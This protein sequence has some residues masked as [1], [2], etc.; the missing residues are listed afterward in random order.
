MEYD[1]SNPNNKKKPPNFKPWKS[2]THQKPDVNPKPNDAD[3]T[4]YKKSQYRK[5]PFG[6][7]PFTDE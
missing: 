5:T 2:T 6:K 7:L 3:A 1:K 4:A